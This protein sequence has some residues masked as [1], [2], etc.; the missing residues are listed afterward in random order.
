MAFAG[1]KLFGKSHKKELLGFDF[2]DEHLKIVHARVSATKREVLNIL[3]R[4]IRGLSDDDIALFVQQTIQH[5][6]ITA[7]RVFVS[8][9]LRAVI[10]RSIEVP[11]RDPDEIQEIV[12]LQAS[13]HT[14]YS[15]AEIIVDTLNLGVL[16]QSYTRVLLVIVPRDVV[17]RHA[18]IIEK[19]NLKLERIFFAPEGL[20]LA[21]SKIMNY[22]HLDEALAIA[23]V[24]HSFSSFS[25]IRRDELL[26]FR[27]MSIGAVQLS[28]DKETYH[29]RFAEE[30]QKSLEAYTM[31]EA[32]PRPSQLVLTGVTIEDPGLDTLLTETL[33]MNLKHQTYYN[34]FTISEPTRAIAS[35]FKQLSFFD[36]IAPLLL[37]DKLK[38]DLISEERR[39][40]I[41]LEGRARE[42][43]KTGLFV[44]LLLAAAFGGFVEKVYFKRTYLQSLT[45]RYK[46]VKEEAKSLEQQ[47]AKIQLVKDAIQNRGHSLET[48]TELYDTLPE[49]VR[50]SEIK[51][52]ESTGF[53]VKGSS[54][55]RTSVFNFVANLEKSKIF[56]NAKTKYM[57]TRNETG[58]DISDFEIAA[59]LRG[60]KA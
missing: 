22:D 14:P 5:L 38:I 36:L 32:G 31:D 9:S 51:Y 17:A 39:L 28:E 23:H 33:K 24:D 26:F 25:V 49:D 57:T 15:R 53:S 34:H 6:K 10:T 52:D 60:G 11:S 40:K 21:C 59:L 56:K 42:I 55:V 13:R 1:L 12:G 35:S 4:E 16:R 27:G 7:A 47:F 45:A 44:L 43:L 30:L 58:K 19:A 29:D 50:V 8:A 18:K 41:Q 3:C 20:S 46:P 54:A 48:L 2:S 37:F